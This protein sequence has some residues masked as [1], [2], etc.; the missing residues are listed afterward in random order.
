MAAN[1]SGA[2]MVKHRDLVASGRDSFITD[3]QAQA[4]KRQKTAKQQQREQREQEPYDPSQV[5]GGAGLA[6]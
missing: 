5:G 4:A 2:G 6:G 3:R 1:P